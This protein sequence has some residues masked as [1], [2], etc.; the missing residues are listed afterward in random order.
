M[1][2]RR[3]T[4]S[5]TRAVA[6]TPTRPRRRWVGP[7]A[8]ALVATAAVAA[9]AL[10][11]ESP[12]RLRA[13]AEAS[14]GVEDWAGALAAWEAFNR[15][16]RADSRSLL[17]EARAALALGRAARAERALVRA[18]AVTPADPEP[19][20]LRLELLRMEGRDVEANRDGW[21]AFRAVAAD[22]RREVLRAVTLALLDDAP[23]DLARETLRR[24]AGA[25]PDDLDARAALAR[26]VAAMPRQGDPDASSRASTLQALLARAPGHLGVRE[27]LVAALADAG[28][29]GRGRLALEGWPADARDARYDRLRGRWDL[30]YDHQPGRAVEALTR[31]LAELPHDWRSRYRLARA[32]FADG[33]EA[34]ARRVA[35]S[36]ALLREALDPA[37]L[38]RRLS[39]DLAHLD[40]PKSRLDLADL[41]EGAGLSRLADA[42]RVDAATGLSPGTSRGA[43]AGLP[44]PRPSR[45]LDP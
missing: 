6:A 25:D 12:G 5:P 18:I 30:E 43:G 15:T 38:G 17:A 22:S 28:D 1:P 7:L 41:C 8:I 45:T 21:A 23:D 34:E 11:P 14:A 24:W 16:D 44:D 35:A 13:R 10:W 40:D 4:T 26:R 9:R 33:R 36:V 19:A 2:R 31:A 20:L 42:W 27:A 3:A 37:P 32:L 29:P 39:A